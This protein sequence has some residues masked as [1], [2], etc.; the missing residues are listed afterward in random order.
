MALQASRLRSPAP[1]QARRSTSRAPID[2]AESDDPLQPLRTMAERV[3]KEVEKFAERVDLWH[4]HGNESAEAKY[5]TTVKMVGKFRDIAAATVNDLKKQS[6]YENQEALDRSVRRRVVH[7]AQ[8]PK[9]NAEGDHGR[10]IQSLSQSTEPAA[11]SEVTE[12]R[13]WQT[14]LAT[15]ELLRVVI[16]H[17]HPRPGRDVAAEKLAQRAKMEVFRY[18]PNHEIWERFLLEDDPAKEKAIVMRWLEQTARN[19]ESDIQSITAQLEAESGKDTDTWTS[20]W[21]ETKSKIKQEKRMRFLD[22]PIRPDE[23]SAQNLRNSD[24]TSLLV[25]QLDPDAASRQSRTL[26][27]SDEYYERALWM[28]CYEM[29]RRGEPWEKIADWCKERSEAWRGVSIGAAYESHPDGGPNVSGSTVGFLFRRMCNFAAVGSERTYESAVYGLLGGESKVVEPVCR[30]WDDHLY[31]RYNALILSRFDNYLQ[32]AAILRVQQDL[33]RKFVFHDA[34]AEL[35]DWDRSS[36][37]VVD[38]LKKQKATAKEASTPLKLIQGSLISRTM[39]ALLYDVGTAILTILQRDERSTNL[40]LSPDGDAANPRPLTIDDQEIPS[41][42]QE[43]KHLATDTHGLR[44]LVHIFIVLWRGLGIYSDAPTP[45]WTLIANV[46]CAYIEFLRLTRRIQLIPLYAAQLDQERQVHC[47]ARILPDITNAQEQKRFI[48]LMDQYHL[49]SA[50]IILQNYSLVLRNTGLTDRNRQRIQR[51]DLLEPTTADQLLW[52]GK[53]I[54]QE[55]SNLEVAPEEDALIDALQWYMHLGKEVK[56]HLVNVADSLRYFLLH[57]RLGA[58]IK[59]ITDMSLETISLVKTETLCG[60]GVDI[61]LPDAEIQNMREFHN[62]PRTGRA[63]I[64]PSN[65]P[66]RDTHRDRIIELRHLSQTY[67]DL[68]QLVRTIE[69][70]QE[71]RKEEET[72]ISAKADTLKPSTQRIKDIYDCIKVTID[73]LLVSFLTQSANG[74]SFEGLPDTLPPNAD[75]YVTRLFYERADFETLKKIY[76]PEILIAYLS[77]LQAASYF[78]TKDNSLK[79]MDLATVIAD[80][81]GEWMQKALMKS[82]RMSEFVDGIAHVSRAM[83]LLTEKSKDK[84]GSIGKTKRGSRGETARVWDLNVRN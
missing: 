8:A 10:S 13:Q 24:N 62:S 48:S 76:I 20:G 72:L 69:L 67:Y 23:P 74:K 30:T 73:S 26:E 31:A 17:H 79:A 47:L 18:S 11:S 33:A 40:I 70:L 5:Q 22:R 68:Q 7:M 4:A 57:G 53:R 28:V 3:G 49:G 59:L 61:T 66:S 27:K 25:S 64:V 35:G 50:Q 78:M 52:P 75:A 21:L 12:L 60:Y 29:I 82:G 32:T 36:S 1:L 2:P 84:K 16:E 19:S 81:S 38:Q 44:V 42:A 71:W 51:Y 37:L 9:R 63:S 77:V 43:F 54:R 15:W 80:D 39:E 65:I 56:H 58:A 46:V 6:D 45:R 34:V 41:V 55:L 14:E 83:L